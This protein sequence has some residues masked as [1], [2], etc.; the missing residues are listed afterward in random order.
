MVTFDYNQWKPFSNLVLHLSKELLTVEKAR[1]RTHFR[2]TVHEV[3]LLWLFKISIFIK[4]N[5]QWGF[6]LAYWWARK[7]T[8]CLAAIPPCCRSSVSKIVICHLD[9][10]EYNQLGSVA[11]TRPLPCAK[12]LLFPM[13][14][15]SLAGRLCSGRFRFNWGNVIFARGDSHLKG[16]GMLVWNFELTPLKETN[17][18]VAQPFFFTSESDHFKLWLF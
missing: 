18:G 9:A 2:H 12:L 3:H 13:S 10:L 15:F 6:S 16:A 14:V 11:S 17:L 7:A 8:I 4:Q 5:H 1:A